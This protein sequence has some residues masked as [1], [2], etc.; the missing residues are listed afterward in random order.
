MNVRQRANIWDDVFEM[1]GRAINT[2]EDTVFMLCTEESDVKTRA[3]LYIR[4]IPHFHRWREQQNKQKAYRL[5]LVCYETLG[6]LYEQAN[7]TMKLIPF[8]GEKH[9][10]KMLERAQQLYHRAHAAYEE[11]LIWH[12]L[13]NKAAKRE[14]YIRAQICFENAQ[15]LFL[16]ANALSELF[17]VLAARLDVV[18][19]ISPYAVYLKE[20]EAAHTLLKQHPQWLPHLRTFERHTILKWWNIS[21]YI[22][23]EQRDFARVRQ[24][25][26]QAVS[27]VVAIG[28]PEDQCVLY[29][30]WALMEY[31][32]N[33]RPMALALYQ[34]SLT[35][36]RLYRPHDIGKYHREFE[37]MRAHL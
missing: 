9:E 23:T 29:Q 36:C 16:S 37:R 32:A 21:L 7:I 18:R 3:A 22:A 35:L 24:L 5:A 14:T 2:L 6:D 4:L 19:R 10:I 17:E 30:R 25:Y 1:F 20:H 31:T 11:G 13:G 26:Q 33:Q 27:L 15:S 12:V 34:W 28:S 8:Q